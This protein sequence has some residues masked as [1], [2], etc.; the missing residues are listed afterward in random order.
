MGS[1]LGKD[2]AQPEA[3]PARQRVETAPNTPAPTKRRRGGDRSDPQ[4][5]PQRAGSRDSRENGGDADGLGTSYTDRRQEEFDDIRDIVQITTHRF[6]DVTA[7]PTA[8][9]AKDLEERHRAYGAGGARHVDTRGVAALEL[10]P[11][12]WANADSARGCLKPGDADGAAAGAADVRRWARLVSEA[13]VGV[14]LVDTAP[15]GGLV[16]PTGKL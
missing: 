1:C 16:V 13:A 6:I 3:K 8:L 7:R 11:T 14:A 15:L 4:A 12:A 10:P 5:T 9:G 2:D